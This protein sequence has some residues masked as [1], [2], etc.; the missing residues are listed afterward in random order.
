MFL[1]ACS[2]DSPAEQAH[3]QQYSLMRD[4]PGQTAYSKDATCVRSYVQPN[5]TVKIQKYGFIN[6]KVKSGIG[7]QYIIAIRDDITDSVCTVNVLNVTPYIFA[8]SVA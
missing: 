5:S 1:F 3:F 6:D 8:P 7:S 4:Y 2:S